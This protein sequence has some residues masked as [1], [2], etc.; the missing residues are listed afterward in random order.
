MNVIVVMAV[1]QAAQAVEDATEREDGR[2]VKR[3]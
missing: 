2:A 1:I 3:W